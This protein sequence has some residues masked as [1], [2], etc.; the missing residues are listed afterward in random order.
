[1]SMLRKIKSIQE[2]KFHYLLTHSKVHLSKQ[3]I[4]K[5]D[6]SAKIRNSSI[7]I[8]KD[9]TITIGKNVKINNAEIY[10]EKGDL[11]IN[12]F[13]II[14]S[15]SNN[16]LKIIIHDG[17]VSIGDHT[18]IACNRIWVRFGGVLSI[19]NFTNINGGSEIRCDEKIIIG[20]YVRI[21][22]D[23]RIWDTNTHR[24][25]S[26][27]DRRNVIRNHFPFFGFEDE[28]P[29]TKP[30]FIGDDCWLGE[31]ASILKGTSLGNCVNVGYKT[32]LVGQH[33][34]SNNTVVQDIIIKIIGKDG[35]K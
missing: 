33:I 25:L 11:E 32:V 10:V 16:R 7:F 14:E 35:N 34:N 27:E 2:I 19:G 24:M 1:M 21:S 29:S 3:S 15:N 12:D 23:T 28:R 5:I 4:C 17:N 22:Y 26:S 9:A 30:I 31:G 6:K 8:A 18:K 13:C 20:S